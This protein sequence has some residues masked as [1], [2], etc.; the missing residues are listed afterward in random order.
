MS[1]PD[2]MLAPLC[3][4]WCTDHGEQDPACWSDYS[5]KVQLTMEESYPDADAGVYAY[6]ET[7]AHREVVYLHLYRPSDNDFRDI[8]ASV[9]LT[10]DEA[11]QLAQ[12]LVAAA[13]LIGTEEPR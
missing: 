3:T 13:D 12:H 9:H 8:D 11:R 2:A 4:P 1:N 10:A 6:R 7:P 5:R